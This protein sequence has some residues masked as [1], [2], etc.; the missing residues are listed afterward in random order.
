MLRLRPG[1]APARR[2]LLLSRLSAARVAAPA[3]VE[4]G[5]RQLWGCFRSGPARRGVLF[6]ACGLRAYRARKAAKAA[7]IRKA[8]DL[9]ARLIG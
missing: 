4:T 6:D 1:G 2:L 7:T 5:L 9:A 8:I 3:A